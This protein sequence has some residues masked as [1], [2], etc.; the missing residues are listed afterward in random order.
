MKEQLSRQVTERTPLQRQTATPP[1]RG[2]GTLARLQQEVG[3]HAVGRLI[4]T[5]LKISQPG[6]EFER[7]A[8]RVAE[9]VINSVVPAPVVGRVGTS[10]VQRACRQCEDEEEQQGQHHAGDDVTLQRK[11]A[12]AESG[13]AGAA[14]QAGLVPAGGGE[15]LGASIR[16]FFEPRFGYD[17]SRVRVHRDAHAAESA[18][19]VDALAYT[20]GRDVVFGAGQYAPESVEGRRLLAHELAHTIQQGAETRL[21]RQCAPALAATPTP[22]G[23]SVLNGDAFLDLGRVSVT[24]DISVGPLAG[25]FHV[26]LHVPRELQR[27]VTPGF[28][29]NMTL[30]TNL[31]LNVSGGGARPAAASTGN[32]LCVFI[33]FHRA[34]DETGATQNWYADLRIL[35]GGHL[36][37]P[38]QIGL[39]TPTGAATTAP[40]TGTARIQLNLT[41]DL[42]ASVGP[43]TLNTLADL[44][45]IWASLQSQVRDRLALEIG[46]I[47][48]PLSLRTSAALTVPVPISG[49]DATQASVIPVNVLGQIEVTAQASTTGEDFTLRLV[50]GGAGTALGG[51]VAIELS[52]RGRLRGPLPSTIRLADLSGD[53]MRGLLANSSGSGEL[54]GRI[55]A[56]GIPGSVHADFR[57]RDNRVTGD[58]TFLSPVGIGGGTFRYGLN[59][60]LSADLGMLGLTRLA[61]APAQQ[62]LPWEPERIVGQQP[63]DFG[64]SV[65]GFGV[66]GVHMT[67]TMTHILSAGVGPQFVTTPDNESVKGVYGGLTY[68][69]TFP[70]L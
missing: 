2:P 66:T 25:K 20:V 40:A 19:A 11:P 4:Q 55:S 68:T 16:A 28:L 64:T 42:T 21:S 50:G 56:F 10:Q 70:G 58:A 1:A 17:F 3:N 32:E 45:A 57:L 44:S 34:A 49:G 54:K 60:G 27:A 59:E 65:T 12:G 5:K 24:S 31:S 37:A 6:D 18:R 8:D 9:H 62:R 30:S 13:G 63:Y 35:S 41:N 23:D 48:V 52:G 46:N 36:N 7:E 67:P 26:K 61:I 29:G 33:T 69:L 38:L 53:F 14:A 51:L 39:G 47:Q 43:L 15:A 22:P